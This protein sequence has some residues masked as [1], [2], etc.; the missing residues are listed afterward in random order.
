MAVA[1]KATVAIFNQLL[2]SKSFIPMIKLKALSPK[3][4]PIP[5]AKFQLFGAG[6]AARNMDKTATVNGVNIILWKKLRVDFLNVNRQ[7]QIMHRQ[8]RLYDD[9]PTAKCKGSAI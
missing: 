5:Y 2:T 9:R 8:T 1:A 3:T 7:P 6:W 4:P